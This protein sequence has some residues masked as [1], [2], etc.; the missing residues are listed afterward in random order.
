MVVWFIQRVEHNLNMAKI[1]E[2][3]KY[4]LL[5]SLSNQDMD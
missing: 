3:I 5:S 4:W 2:T 1:M